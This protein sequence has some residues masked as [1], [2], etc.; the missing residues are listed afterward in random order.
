MSARQS[1]NQCCGRAHGCGCRR[2]SAHP[3]A[4]GNSKNQTAQLSALKATEATMRTQASTR[5]QATNNSRSRAILT[6]I[7]SL[8]VVAA[9]AIGAVLALGLGTHTSGSAAL[10]S[11]NRPMI[12]VC[13]ACADEA[14]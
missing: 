1:G 14:L 6:M 4:E 9:A 10:A 2:S 8:V 11:A 7:A 13:R 12:A 5:T 3:P